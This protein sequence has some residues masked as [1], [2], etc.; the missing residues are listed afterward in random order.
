[1]IDEYIL[2]HDRVSI[3]SIMARYAYAIRGRPAEDAAELHI[4][5][6][7]C[8]LKSRQQISEHFLCDL[9]AKGEV[10]VLS[11]AKL[12]AAHRPIPDS[13]DI[14]YFI[15]E[16]YPSLIPKEHEEEIKRLISKLHE[17]NFF[18]LT[19][20]GKPETQQRATASLEEKLQEN[21]SER[22]RKAIEYKI[23]R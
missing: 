9:N 16:R 21:I 18:S 19:F 12:D 8:D 1:M 5:E 13:V 14:T 20:A 17:I 4:Q 7:A 22:Y 10:P 23:Q 11:P 6:E 2:Y 3:C 15:A